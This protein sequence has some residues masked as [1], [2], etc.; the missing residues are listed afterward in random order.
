MAARPNM[1]ELLAQMGHAHEAAREL[2]ADPQVGDPRHRSTRIRM[3]CVSADLPTAH[4]GAALAGG[5]I[6]WIDKDL[7]NGVSREEWKGGVEANKILGC[8]R[9]VSRVRCWLKVC[10]SVSVRCAATVRH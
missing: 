4:Y 8:L 2:L 7:G 1:R 6:A 9:W 5:L 3:L 10:V